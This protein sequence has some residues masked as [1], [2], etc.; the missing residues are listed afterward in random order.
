MRSSVGWIV[1]LA[2]IVCGPAWAGQGPGKGNGK[3]HGQGAPALSTDAAMVTIVTT[4]ERSL[5]QGYFFPY[6][7]GAVPALG[8]L[9]PLPPGIAKKIAR[10]GSLPPGIAKRYLPADLATQLPPR[11][12]QQWL[13]VGTD[14][15]L[16]DIATSIV[17]DVLRDCL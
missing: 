2:L 12:G 17:I 14:V 10:G 16:I 15:V 9:K 8:P 7:G 11:P 3:G 6:R 5:I 4:T 1:V 13:V